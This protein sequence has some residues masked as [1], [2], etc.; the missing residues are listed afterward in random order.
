MMANLSSNTTTSFAASVSA[1]DPIFQ[2]FPTFF[3]PSSS[4]ARRR[5]S[6]FN[7]EKELEVPELVPDELYRQNEDSDAFRVVQHLNLLD[8]FKP[9]NNNITFDTNTLFNSNNN[10]YKS[11][12]LIEY[13]HTAG[14]DSPSHSIH[15]NSPAT[16]SLNPNFA[17]QSP[18]GE[19]H[20]QRQP[21][22][23]HQQRPLVPTAVVRPAQV[24]K[25]QT[26]L[27]VTSSTSNLATITE[28]DTKPD[29]GVDPVDVDMEN[30]EDD[31]K[32][33]RP[34]RRSTAGENN[35]PTLLSEMIQPTPKSSSTNSSKSK[36]KTS[37]SSTSSS[38]T[39][40]VSRSK[41]P[42][43]AAKKT[44]ARSAAKQK[45]KSRKALIAVLPEDHRPARG[46]GRSKQLQ[47]MTKD[48]VKAEAAVR[49]EKNRV[50][51]K[52][53]RARKKGFID[54]LKSQISEFELK[55]KIAQKEIAHLKSRL[56]QM[57]KQQLILQQHH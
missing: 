17:F 14:G 25:N 32:P 15:S 56:E 3:G 2:H 13:L 43:S 8:E 30:V 40:S 16:S 57:E 48:M 19:Q 38:S 1:V 12:G 22:K 37:S 21:Q 35:L 9:L 28:I 29:T 11:A 36:S 39:S 44:P 7:I 42:S 46:R 31:R 49:A 47:T 26:D 24:V 5:D 18:E 10:N 4:I 45:A 51:A 33:S 20:Q 6:L 54:D 53:C 50:A 52:E 34:S 27:I 23:S 41:K 55:D